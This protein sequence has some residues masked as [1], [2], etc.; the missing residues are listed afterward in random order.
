MARGERDLGNGGP[1]GPG[2]VGMDRYVAKLKAW[3]YRGP[4]SIEREITGKEQRAN[5][6]EAIGLLERLRKA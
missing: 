3:G 5:I 1:S 4:L 6:R 2:D